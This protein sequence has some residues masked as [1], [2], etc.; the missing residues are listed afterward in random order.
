[1]DCRKLWC[2]ESIV[3]LE[4]CD[5]PW[6]S[7]S[8]FWVGKERSTE[9]TGSWSTR[10]VWRIDGVEGCAGVGE[11]SPD[12]YVLFSLLPTQLETLLLPY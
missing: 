5:V 11:G 4:S 12:I 6:K 3:A 9:M 7:G 8:L 10:N 1:M 2:E